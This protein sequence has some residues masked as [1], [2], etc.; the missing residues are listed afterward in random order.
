MSIKEEQ[1][2]EEKKVIWELGISPQNGG[3]VYKVLRPFAMK[4]C[5]GPLHD[6][7]ESDSVGLS[8]ETATELFFC[9]KI[10]PELPVVGQY[11][12]IRNFVVTI[13]GLFKRFQ[14]GQ[15]LELTDNEALP[16]LREKKI[17]ILREVKNEED[18][19]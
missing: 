1:I 7:R 12:V 4:V 5:D 2:R 13:E 11:E 3:A 16:L 19:V 15:V 17:R 6:A 8:P 10:A 14:C 18:S 9:G